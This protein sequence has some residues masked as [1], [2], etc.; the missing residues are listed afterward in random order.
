MDQVVESDSLLG[1]SLPGSIYSDEDTLLIGRNDHSTCLDTS[2][3]EP[4]ADDI[5]RVSAQEDTTAHTTYGVI[6]KEA[7]IGDGVQWHAGG[8]NSTGDSGQF[9]AFYF[10]ECVVGIPLLTLAVRGIR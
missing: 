4:G 10:E 3:W 7:A 8:L 6:Q 2:V 9:S 1:H 5:S